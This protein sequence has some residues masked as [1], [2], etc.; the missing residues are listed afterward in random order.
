MRKLGFATKL[1]FGIG[2][3]AEGIKTTAFTTFL[4]FYYNQVLGLSGTL[5]GAAAFIALCFDAV[6]D[7][8]VGSLSDSFRSRWGRRHPFM[9]A[10]AIPMAIAFYLIFTPPAGL[11]EIGLFLWLLTFA[12]LVRAAMT[13]YHVPHLALGAELS[14][15]Y[16]ERTAIVGYRTVFG[17]LGGAGTALVGFGIFFTAS[18][19]FPRGQLNPAAYPGF[20]LTGAVLMWLTIWISAIGTHNQIPFLPKS[21]PNPS[22]FG[23]TRVLRET[24]DALRNPSFRALFTGL[25]IFAVLGGAQGT[26]LVHMGTHFYVMTSNQIQLYIVSIIVG[27]AGGTLFARVLNRLIDKKPTMFVAVFLGTT[28]TAIPPLLWVLGLLPPSTDPRMMWIILGCAGLGAFFSVQSATTGASVMADIAD[29][30]ELTMGRRQEGIFFGAISFSGKTAYG[31]G[32]AV[33]GLVIDIIGF[34]AQAKLGSVPHD[35]LVKL[36]LFYGPVVWIFSMGAMLFYIGIRINRRRLA[37]IQTELAIARAR[38]SETG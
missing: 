16:H 3:L 36:G 15:D 20:A 25:I 29:E 8:V 9:Y 33:A 13:L 7:P 32:L 14:T 5:S 17:L 21:N 10:S 38:E 23:L 4:F 1:C 19:G 11:G 22:P 12:V 26:L 31:F 24:R 2:Q 6:S 34:P 18:P 28:F 30:H 35:V 37:E 27:S